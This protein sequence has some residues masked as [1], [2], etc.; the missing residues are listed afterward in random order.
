MGAEDVE[1]G[2]SHT[3][4]SLLK[5]KLKQISSSACDKIVGGNVFLSSSLP[6]RII[7]SRSKALSSS[8]ILPLYLSQARSRDQIPTNAE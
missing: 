1:M 6:R 2:K 3:N 4:E 5:Y 7:F 8:Y